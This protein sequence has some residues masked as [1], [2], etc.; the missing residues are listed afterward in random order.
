MERQ[1]A[2]WFL[3]FF[4]SM[5]TKMF[6]M[7]LQHCREHCQ[8]P[9]KSLEIDCAVFRIIWTQTGRIMSNFTLNHS[10]QAGL[11]FFFFVCS[12]SH[13]TLVDHGGVLVNHFSHLPSRPEGRAQGQQPV[14][15]ALAFP[16]TLPSTGN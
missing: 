12:Y 14:P 9:P 6:A 3:C 4:L 5:I 15:S 11:F 7:W 2:K 8:M 16:S 1:G 10:H 13:A